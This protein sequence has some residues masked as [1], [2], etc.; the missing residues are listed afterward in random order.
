MVRPNLP[1]SSMKPGANTMI[2]SGIAI[3]AT[4]QSPRVR[5]VTCTSS[6]PASKAF[7]KRF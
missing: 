1:G 4:I 7:L 5:S 6:A 2:S 3:S